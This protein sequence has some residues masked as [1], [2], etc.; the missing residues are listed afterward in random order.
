MASIK[1]RG[2]FAPKVAAQV[3]KH[4]DGFYLGLGDRVPRINGAAIVGPTRLNDGDIIS[5]GRVRLSFLYR[6]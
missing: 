5:V 3:H 6:D 2:W 1:L 4:D